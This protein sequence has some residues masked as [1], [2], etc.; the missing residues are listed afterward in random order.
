MKTIILLFIAAIAA[1]AQDTPSRGYYAGGMSTIGPFAVIGTQLNDNTS[2]YVNAGLAGTTTVSAGVVRYLINV[3]NSGIGSFRVGA[4]GEAG[5]AVTG[6]TGFA[7]A[8][9]GVVA[10]DISKWTKV[11][12]LSI[13]AVMKLEKTGDVAHPA[14]GLGFSKRF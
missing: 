4:L 3:Q 1:F 8:L 2:A 12:N 14:Y 10:Y 13:I 6:S 7:G 9:G 5:A 11:E